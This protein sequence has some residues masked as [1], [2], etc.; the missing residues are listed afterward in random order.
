MASQGAAASTKPRPNSNNQ[1]ARRVAGAR[2]G[3]RTTASKATPRRKAPFQRVSKASPASKPAAS[4]GQGQRRPVG[5]MHQRESSARTVNSKSESQDR[6]FIKT[7]VLAPT[8]AAVRQASRASQIERTR[9][10]TEPI[11]SAK[12]MT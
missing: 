2:Q 5:S 4:A 3:L 7:G 6:L 9:P 10:K 11:S 8:T 12:A 1:N